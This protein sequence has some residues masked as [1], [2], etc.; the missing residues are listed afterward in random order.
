MSLQTGKRIHG[1]SWDELP[2]DDNVIELVES[3]ALRQNQPT[4]DNEN[5]IFGWD[6]DNIVDFNQIEEIEATDAE[7]D[8][9]D[10]NNPAPYEANR[11]ANDDPDP[12]EKVV[13]DGESSVDEVDEHNQ[14][15][16]NQYM[17]EPDIL[18]NEEDEIDS[19]E[20]N[21]EHVSESSDSD[22][23]DKSRS[24]YDL[25]DIIDDDSVKHF[26]NNL[27]TVDDSIFDRIDD[28]E[29]EIREDIRKSETLFNANESNVSENDYLSD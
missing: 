19:N 14:Q 27:T 6:I 1:N 28:L 16:E 15:P 13:T 18:L 8:V 10:A 29:E 20:N 9:N 2:F 25:N 22:E 24:Y 21:I 11:N 3:F 26:E 23:F 5:V 12:D 17:I 7:D 4:L